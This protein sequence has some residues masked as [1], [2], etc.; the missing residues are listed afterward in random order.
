MSMSTRESAVPPAAGVSVLQRLQR[1]LLALCLLLAPL[2]LAGWFALCPQYGDPGCPTNAQPLA[3]LAAFRAAPP[4]WLQ[5]F[6]WLNV[7]VPYLYPLS[8]LGLGLLAM[9]RAP[10]LA[11]L[12]LLAGWVGSVPWGFIADALFQMHTAAGLGQ[13][14]AYALLMHA[15]FA[16]PAILL[17]ATGWVFG[18]LLG[19]LLLG[20][21]LRR[22]GVIP[23]WS[24]WLFVVSA[25]LMGPIAYGSGLGWLQ[26]GGYVLVCLA[27]L[28]AAR[29][30]LRAGIAALA[31]QPNPRVAI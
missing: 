7:L 3:V 10:W 18:H 16:N 31:P 17:V 11:T 19:Y 23:A 5:L 13:D 12:G 26:V 20:L 6:L 30:L 27:S 9:R 4:A 2:S 22:A 14:A 28:P 8:Y 25:V 21:W 24:A 15:Y 29:V 1:A